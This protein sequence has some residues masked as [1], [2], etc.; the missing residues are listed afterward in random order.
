MNS[1]VNQLWVTLTIYSYLERMGFG[2]KELRQLWDAVL[3]IT[4]VNKI[5]HSVAV[6]KFL[7]DV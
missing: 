6:F 4:Q 5:S 7:K 2:L 3:E 1:Q